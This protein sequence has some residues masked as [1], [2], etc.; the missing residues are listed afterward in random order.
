MAVI[1]S[2][3]SS[4]RTLRALSSGSVVGPEDAGYDAARMPWNVVDQRPAVVI[5]PETETDIAFAVAFAREAG[6]R[7][8]AQGTGHNAAPLGD[9]SD[10]MLIQTG[11]MRG[12]EFDAAGRRVRVQA[13]A[14]W[15]DVVPRASE[16]GLAALHGSSPN[17][18]IAGYSLGGGIGYYARKHGLQ[19]NSVTAIEMITADGEL[20]RADADHDADLFWALR[21][22]GGNFGVVTA[23]EFKL[24]PV[25]SAYAG[26][27]FWPWERGEEVL[28]R[29]AEWTREVP[30]EVTSMG[31]LLQIPDMP[32]A[33][34]F[35][36][37]KQIAIINAAYLGSEEE[38]KRIFAPLR[39]MGPEM[40][41]FGMMPPVGL[42][43]LHGDP[44]DGMP[45]ESATSILDELPHDAVRGVMEAAGPDSGS[46][47][48]MAELRHLG[49]AAGRSGDGHG[50]LDRIDGEYVMF[51]GGL[52]LDDGMRAAV[53]ADAARL[54]ETLAPYGRGG[55][56]LNFA[57]QRVDTRTAY[58]EDAFAR[59]QRVRSHV[60]P[61][62]VFRANHEIA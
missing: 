47:L 31:R 56:Y 13:G 34:D 17:V 4:L 3:D 14:W 32:E 37:G 50:A 6:L 44:E 19:A 52:A 8:N 59:L 61:E 39:E 49:G 2:T 29:W 51:A 12:V 10:T 45:I 18:G 23:L 62:G 16:M 21:G 54:K 55:H 41:L 30:D 28:G 22:G 27:M 35:L 43:G 53:R 58:G 24:Y 46:A 7:I 40:D 48:L 42:S 33:P 36:R 60:D 11:R 20:I 57:E 15:E 5:Q 38:G 9:M 26:M 1:H 25:E